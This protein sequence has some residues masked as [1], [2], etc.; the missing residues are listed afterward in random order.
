MRVVLN[1]HDEIVPDGITV[2][3]LLDQRKVQP[4]RVA[5]E[6]NEDIV[7][8]RTFDETVIREGDRIEIATFVGGG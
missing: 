2:G 5:V 4:I 1:G 7:R 6:I 8:R 3:D